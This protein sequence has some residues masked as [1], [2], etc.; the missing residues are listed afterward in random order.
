MQIIKKRR[1]FASVIQQETNGQLLKLHGSKGGRVT[2]PPSVW[3]PWNGHLHLLSEVA[4]LAGGQLYFFNENGEI[5]LP[6]FWWAGLQSRVAST[7]VEVN[8][9]SPQSTDRG[10]NNF[11]KKYLNLQILFWQYIIRYISESPEAFIF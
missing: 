9:V 10:V 6:L 11:N 2:P 7:E 8:A 1:P 3:A 5:Q 4:A